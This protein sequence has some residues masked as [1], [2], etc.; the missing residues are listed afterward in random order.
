ME[1][2]V[3]SDRACNVYKVFTADSDLELVW[4]C[5]E[6]MFKYPC[7]YRNFWGANFKKYK[8]SILKKDNFY[9]TVKK[10]K[11]IFLKNGLV[12]YETFLLASFVYVLL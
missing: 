6:L 12:P 7:T 4:D 1:L 10:K 9:A 8:E 2:K 11:R 3:I 5:S